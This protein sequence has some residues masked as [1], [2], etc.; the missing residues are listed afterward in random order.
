MEI[1]SYH[2]IMERIEGLS[3]GL[4]CLRDMVNH[5]YDEEEEH[6]NKKV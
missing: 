3:E 4:N 5:L 1:A 6:D 2:E